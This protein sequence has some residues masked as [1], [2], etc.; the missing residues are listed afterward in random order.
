MA[1]VVTNVSRMRGVYNKLTPQLTAIEELAKEKLQMEHDYELAYMQ[2]LFQLR[3]EKVPVAMIH[4]VAKGK[5]TEQKLKLEIKT[6]E[7]QAAVRV[8]KVLEVKASLLQ[9]ISKY[10][11]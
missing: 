11:E 6:A 9:S 7:Y 8:L 1:D 2:M 5:L 10:E 3:E 4:N